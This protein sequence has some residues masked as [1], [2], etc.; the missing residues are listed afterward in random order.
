LKTK[1]LRIAEARAR[2][3]AAFAWAVAAITVLTGCN[4]AGPD[5]RS[6]LDL[7]VSASNAQTPVVRGEQATFR[8]TVSNPTS[9]TVHDLN[10]QW[11]GNG[12]DVLFASA[13]C[14]AEGGA[15][16]PT[17]LDGESISWKAP[18][19]PGGGSLTFDI[20]V[21]VRFGAPETIG[22]GMRVDA[23]DRAGAA[24]ATGYGT[25]TGD[26]RSG[27]YRMYSSS[28]RLTDTTLDFMASSFQP[29]DGS[30]LTFEGSA[31]A[32]SLPGGHSYFA[33]PPDLL[34]GSL[35]AGSGAGPEPFVAARRFAETVTE[36]EGASFNV[37]SRELVFTQWQTR[38]FAAWVSNG[39]LT[40]CVDAVL[41][42]PASCPV[43]SQHH[44]ALTVT[45]GDFVGVDAAHGETLRFRVAKSASSMFFLRAGTDADFYGLQVGVQANSEP[46]DYM[47]L[48][49]TSQGAWGWPEVTDFDYSADWAGQAGDA[50]SES[51]RASRMRQANDGMVQWQRSSDGATFYQALDVPLGVAIGAPSSAAAGEMRLLVPALDYQMLR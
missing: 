28:G 24:E 25:V 14:R 27:S 6:D 19:M 10:F 50:W 5:N 48:G 9:S 26:A 22:V 1:T 7:T 39:M 34:V 17:Y 51:A 21:T 12:S 18:S 41:Y 31:S 45:N 35:D 37:F 40:T 8:T 43:A 29:G 11:I 3:G 32:Y 49:V 20:S 2:R 46:I 47:Y 16:C 23:V 13:S 42:A 44:H 36:L 38:A 30:S 4:F 15:I 33:T